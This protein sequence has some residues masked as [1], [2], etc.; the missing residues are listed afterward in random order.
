MDLTSRRILKGLQG[1][2]NQPFNPN[3]QTMSN[4]H[5][6]RNALLTKKQ[7][8]EERR[9]NPTGYK[10]KCQNTH[11]V[12][13]NAVYRNR[14]KNHGVNVS[15]VKTVSRRHMGPVRSSSR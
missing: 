6:R 7:C 2:S 13:N 14:L 3:Y 11:M 9:K 12:N 8:D 5:H 1:N 10:I 15:K 4:Y